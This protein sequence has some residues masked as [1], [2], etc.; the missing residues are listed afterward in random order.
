MSKVLFLYDE[1]EPTVLMAKRFFEKFAE[2]K[3]IKIRFIKSAKLKQEDFNW[4]DVILIIRGQAIF[5]AEIAKIAAK[6]Q[7]YVVS[8]YDDDFFELKDFHIRRP[9]QEKAITI[10]LQNSDIVLATNN[11]LGEKYV[12]ISKKAKFVKSDTS[13]QESE[14]YIQEEKKEGIHVVYYVND[15][16]TE[17]FEQVIGPAIPA[18]TEK[19]GKNLTWSFIGVTPKMPNCV[20]QDNIYFYQHLSLDQFR[21]LLRKGRF[22]FGIAPLI[23][24]EFTKSKY[25]NKFMEFTTAGLAC[26]YSDVAPYHGFIE[27][28]K[29]GFL[30]ENTVDG[31]IGAFEKA[32]NKEAREK[33]VENAKTQIREKFS[34]DAIIKR[35]VEEIPELLEYKKR[36][37]NISKIK[38]YQL[39][40]YSKVASVMDLFLRAKGR[41][42]VE[43][44]TNLIMYIWQKKVLK[45]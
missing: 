9:M 36:K 39:K 31:W 19:Y 14:L 44:F 26:I 40:L 6:K 23:E 24:N 30:C 1:I 10:I 34:Q 33:C 12:K 45:T 16:T 38:F 37:Q 11:T 5:M 2:K 27:D 4:S 25:I 21:K 8:F 43:G 41:W 28:K 13:V 17:T 20:S 22:T 29:N 7:R 18:L 35:I 32:C 3:N 15:G 42:K